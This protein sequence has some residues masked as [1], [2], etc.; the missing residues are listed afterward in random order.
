MQLLKL[1]VLGILGTIALLAQQQNTNYTTLQWDQGTSTPTVC[2]APGFFYNTSTIPAITYICDKTGHFVSSGGGGGSTPGGVVNDLQK[3]TS[4]TTLGAAQITDDGTVIQVVSAANSGGN[5]P[6]LRIISTAEAGA[7]YAGA[8]MLGCN[9]PPVISFGTAASGTLAN[10]TYTYLITTGTDQTLQQPQGTTIN[11]SESSPS[12]LITVSVTGVANATQI[13][14]W[15]VDDNA[16]ATENSVMQAFIYRCKS[17]ANCT[18]TPAGYANFAS[19]GQTNMT[20]AQYI[21]GGISAG[22]NGPPTTYDGS[23]QVGCYPAEGGFQPYCATTVPGGPNGDQIVGN[24][25]HAW[26]GASDIWNY[27]FVTKAG[28]TFC[29]SVTSSDWA[30]QWYTGGDKAQLSTV[31]LILVNGSGIQLG[32]ASSTLLTSDFKNSGSIT[33]GAVADGSCSSGTFTLTSAAVGDSL[34]PV[35]PVTLNNGFS[36]RMYVSATNTITTVICNLSGGS[37]TPGALTY[38]ALVIH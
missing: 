6:A 37:L 33:F 31:P 7:G 20:N 4:S 8:F 1:L 17:P 34:A 2:L 9:P 10:G 25:C 38:G 15:P 3:K 16:P 21:D 24:S 29:N 5:C 18:A 22:T 11:W 13:V 14:S 12:N 30:A 27:N 36:G 23:F 19:I 28:Q 32:S 26:D 35:W